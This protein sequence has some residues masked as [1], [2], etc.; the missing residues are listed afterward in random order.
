[1]PLNF[2]IH[3]HHYKMQNKTTDKELLV[4][5]FA[6][7]FG[8]LVPIAAL[9]QLFT[10]WSQ[11][12]AS[13]VSIGTWS[14]YFALSTFWSAYSI[15]HRQWPLIVMYV[16]QWALQIFIIVGIIRFG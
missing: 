7:L 5:R 9:P 1:M 8:I 6:Y 10:I 11:Q 13:A 14:A 15:V 3:H 12:D 16:S 2:G 4:D